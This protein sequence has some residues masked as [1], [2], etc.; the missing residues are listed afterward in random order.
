MDGV[1]VDLDERKR[2]KTALKLFGWA[3]PDGWC[4]GL[5]RQVVGLQ[6][7]G[8]GFVDS[9]SSQKRQLV[10]DDTAEL[11]RQIEAFETPLG[12][13]L[14]RGLVKRITNGRD[15]CRCIVRDRT[16]RAERSPSGGSWR[17]FVAPLWELRK[18]AFTQG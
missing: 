1:W 16:N 13:A 12:K 9:G 2:P 6:S 15:L 3:T 14:Y 5:R 11:V 10:Q 8:T 18:L 7:G 4:Q 17:M